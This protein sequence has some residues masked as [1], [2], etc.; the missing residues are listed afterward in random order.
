M[1][2][3]LAYSLHIC[4]GAQPSENALTAS[5]YRRAPRFRRVSFRRKFSRWY[6]NRILIEARRNR[7]DPLAM[8]AIA[9][10]ESSYRPW[11]RGV[12]G[13]RRAAEVGVWQL[14]PHDS[15]VR[16]A[17]RT[18]EGCQPPAHLAPW[19]RR[20]WIRRRP[21]KPCADQIVANRRKYVGSFTV[22]ELRDYILG[23]YIAAF[24]I[25]RHIDRVNR[26]RIRSKRIRGCRNVSRETQ[27]RLYRYG[28]Y[29][30]GMK[31]PSNY[32]VLRICK[33]WRI[34]RRETMAFDRLAKKKT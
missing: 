13:S 25:R 5:I 16:A 14:I 21:G 3:L 11:A 27:Y 1:S 26:R 18:L 10:T 30:S 12:P 9:W 33:R 6:A 17:R 7:L 31:R 23:T 19:R 20:I 24:E 28:F 22:T 34:L 15:P 29:N 2:I 4:L 32:Y 8:A